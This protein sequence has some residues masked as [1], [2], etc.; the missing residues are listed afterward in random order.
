MY[1]YVGNDPMNW[2]DPM[3][4]AAQTWTCDFGDGSVCTRETKNNCDR[5]CYES[6]TRREAPPASRP[7]A[8][9]A[10]PPQKRSCNI[11]DY[12]S[13][14]LKAGALVAGAVVVVG[15]VVIAAA[16]A[17][18][19]AGAAATVV[20][21]ATVTGIGLTAASVVADGVAGG[22]SSG[23]EAGLGATVDQTM[24]T[25]GTAVIGGIKSNAIGLV[26]SAF[27]FAAGPNCKV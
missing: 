13:Q 19:G 27:D 25:V 9:L 26:K 8:R 22:Y 11:A 3:G 14:T 16:P 7:P 15:G 23:F 12:A 20:G 18:A 24:G 10:L 6:L 4:L 5:N 2:I 1:A 21:V 17:A